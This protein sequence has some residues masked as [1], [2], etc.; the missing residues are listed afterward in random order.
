[1]RVARIPTNIVTKRL[2]WSS[3][4]S[5]GDIE[6]DVAMQKAW[7]NLLVKVDEIVT[8]QQYSNK[9]INVLFR[10][11]IFDAKSSSWTVTLTASIDIA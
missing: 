4:T 6:P 2:V 1:M 10:N 8:G 9:Y 11:D 7:E 3:G 5:Y